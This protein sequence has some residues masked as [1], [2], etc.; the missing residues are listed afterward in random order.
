MAEEE[1]KVTKLSR[2]I[3]SIFV[4]KSEFDRRVSI[5]DECPYKQTLLAQ[6]QC[7]ICGCFID[8]KAKLKD[9]HCPL[10]QPKW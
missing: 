4:E 9:M 3:G 2:I 7:G 6:R 10:G 5:C 8:I 1:K